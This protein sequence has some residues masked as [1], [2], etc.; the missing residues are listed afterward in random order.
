MTPLAGTTTATRALYMTG[1]AARVAAA[2][3]QKGWRVELDVRERTPRANLAYA[4]RRGIG[5]VVIVD[6]DDE[7]RQRYV[8]R[9][10]ETGEE[11][12]AALSPAQ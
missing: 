10:M 9:E 11:H 4:H 12:D 5:R 7:A 6:A 8:I 3:R 2:L 1:N